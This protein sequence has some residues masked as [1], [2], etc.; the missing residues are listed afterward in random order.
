MEV[1]FFGCESRQDSLE[2]ETLPTYMF[3]PSQFKEAKNGLNHCL[4]K[5]SRLCG[6]IFGTKGSP[7]KPEKIRNGNH[8]HFAHI[9]QRRTP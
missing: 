4:K 3:A 5:L 7:S 6:G 2:M 9:D 8:F 1:G